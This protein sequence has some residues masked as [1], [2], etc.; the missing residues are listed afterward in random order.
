M[1]QDQDNFSGAQTL[2]TVPA[3]WCPTGQNI[4]ILN[5]TPLSSPF[6]SAATAD[7]PS[8]VV[9]AAADDDI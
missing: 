1:D 4:R 3:C 7:S 6:R 9:D 8:I 2:I 5:E